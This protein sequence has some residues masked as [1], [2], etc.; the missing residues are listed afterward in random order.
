MFLA[1][2]G[3]TILGVFLGI[4]GG[5]LVEANEQS[6]KDRQRKFKKDVV[7]QIEGNTPEGTTGNGTEEEEEEEAE[8]SMLSD[9]WDILVLETPII[10]VVVVLGQTLGYFEGWDVIERCDFYSVLWFY[11]SSRRRV[12]H[13]SVFVRP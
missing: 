13:R 11:C 2:Y 9:I 6:V 10:I 4:Y 7:N 3:I 1:L 5:S 12:A 8:P